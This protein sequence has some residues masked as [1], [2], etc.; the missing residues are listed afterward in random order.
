MAGLTRARSP[1]CAVVVL[2]PCGAR[3]RHEKG[4]WSEDVGQALLDQRLALYRKLAR[5]RPD[6]YASDV[7]ALEGLRASLAERE[8][9]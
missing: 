5:R 2:L 8:T 1:A 6:V 3:Y 9:A 4:T 7:T